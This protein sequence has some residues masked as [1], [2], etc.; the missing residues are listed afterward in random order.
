MRSITRTSGGTFCACCPVVDYLK[1]QGDMA[2]G[3]IVEYVLAVCFDGL[4]AR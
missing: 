4:R 2:D 3:E 1:A